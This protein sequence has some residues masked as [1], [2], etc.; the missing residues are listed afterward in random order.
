[1]VDYNESINLDVT[2]EPAAE[3]SSVADELG[4]EFLYAKLLTSSKYELLKSKTKEFLGELAPFT[5]LLEVNRNAIDENYTGTKKTV[6]ASSAVS[7]VGGA[8]MIAGTVAAP[9]TL[10]A[11]LPLTAVGGVFVAGGTATSLYSQY[12]SSKTRKAYFEE[13]K[14]RAQQ[15]DEEGNDLK[16]LHDDY[17][18]ECVHLAEVVK[19]YYETN[20]SF[21]VDS[22]TL[23]HITMALQAGG[24]NKALTSTVVKAAAI[25]SG[26]ICK[27]GH[28]VA[29]GVGHMRCISKIMTAAKPGI[30]IGSKVAVSFGLALGGIGILIDI[31]TGIMALHDTLGKTKCQE[32]RELTRNI[33]KAKQVVKKVQDYYDLLLKDPNE[34]FEK[35]IAGIDEKQIKE[36]KKEN[37]QLR[38]T[39]QEMEHKHETVIA[40]LEQKNEN[41]RVE[42]KEQHLQLLRTFKEEQEKERREFIEEQEKQRKEMEK[43]MQEFCNSI[44]TKLAINSQQ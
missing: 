25:N 38:I 31:V 39:I 22:D 30:V 9:P 14:E 26:I 12:K 5:E 2:R 34:Y 13:C 32:S 20:Q 8:L 44:C 35:D 43:Q 29:S 40:E 42:M 18:K 41:L 11:S 28:M 37:E 10:G 6:V 1:M 16:E 19:K 21:Q 3:L 23:R 24:N 36:L 17:I 27:A 7:A 15:I 33:E 4:A